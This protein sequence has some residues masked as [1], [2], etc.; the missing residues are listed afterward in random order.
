[1]INT[2]NPISSIWLK[3]AV[4]GGLWAS[5]EIIVGSFLHNIRIPFA[6]GVL[7]SFGVILM[8]AFY[9]MW[10]EK[11]LLWRAGVVCALMKSISPSAIIL[12]PMIG[13]V[14][15]AI[16]LDL[17]I[18]LLGRSLPAIMIAGGLAVT[19]AFAQKILNILVIY[20]MSLVKV[21]L[22]LIDYAARQIGFTHAN[23]WVLILILAGIYFVM[24]LASAVAGY[25]I[26]RRSVELQLPELSPQINPGRTLFR[27][28]E[29]QSYST[30]LL[31]LNLLSIP[32]GI[33]FLNNAPIYISIP[34]CSGYIIFCLVYYPILLR[35]LRN[36]LLWVQL[37]IIIVLS[38]LFWK[39]DQKLN[40]LFDLASLQAGVEMSFRA[41]LVISGFTGISS[42]LRSPLV[43]AFLFKRGLRQVYGAVSL[44]F[45]AL[46]SMLEDAVK[47]RELI[48]QP[49]TAV[50]RILARAC[51][52]EKVFAQTAN[53]KA[54][55]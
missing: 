12:G 53:E 10:P 39:S 33:I 32:G 29:R 14:S 4:A 20:G 6:G 37:V 7:A 54:F 26:G 44:A 52:W 18:R 17:I 11:G 48:R 30:Y 1:L 40:G 41:L 36:P 28:N 43:R 46:P 50:A 38:G 51:Q 21:Y 15:E 45:Q 2:T 16:L 55:K 49:L 8:I 19:A 27:E 3:A 5:V 31:F 23:P 24:G 13:I 25:L 9:R 34:V 35:R 42:E 22:N 47:P